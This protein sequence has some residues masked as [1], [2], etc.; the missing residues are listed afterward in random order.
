MRWGAP[1]GGS[2]W[3]GG[4]GGGGTYNVFGLYIAKPIAWVIA[5]T[6]VMTA[7]GALLQ[8]NGVALYTY[9]LL[10]PDWVLRGEVWRLFTWI[11]LEP[12]P[13]GLVFGCL[14]LYFIGPDLLHRWGR[15]RF[16]LLYFG[17]GAIV[18]LLTCLVARFLVTEV[19]RAPFTGLWPMQEA[20]IIAWAVLM[21][22]RQIR[23]FFVLPLAG[24][25]LISFTIAVT[26]VFAFLNGFPRYIP[27]F[28]AEAIA[29]VYMDVFSFRRAYLRARM[30]MLQRDYKR[31]TT[32]MRVVDR[33]RDEPPRW[34]H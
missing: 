5:A 1:G 32:H 10:G 22:D 8:R 6:L 16:F 19:Y 4:G 33:E 23:V 12:D 31:R 18:G 26:F 2:G 13:L 15:R 20:M 14:L 3:G 30:A 28:I 21:P 7:G 27:H 9:R 11:F 24:R 17:A 29:L 25:H 34:T